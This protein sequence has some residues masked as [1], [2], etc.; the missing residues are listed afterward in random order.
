MC[1]LVI[2]QWLQQK[3]RCDKVVPMTRVKFK[4][5]LWK[6]LENSR[7]FVD[8]IWKKVKC[9]SQYQDKSV[10]VW[11]AHLEYLQS[12]S[13]EFNPEYAPKKDTM[14]RYFRKGLRP[15]VRV[16]IK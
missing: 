13:I 11:A 7:V 6:N 16:E 1:G 3:Q 12:I 4:D 14:I 15:S 9:N 8:S 5:F 10:E 2:Q